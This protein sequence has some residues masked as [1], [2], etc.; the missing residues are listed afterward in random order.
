MREEVL[1]RAHDKDRLAKDLAE[2]AEGTTVMKRPE[3][4]QGKYGA[5]GD[6]R[7]RKGDP[8]IMGAGFVVGDN[9]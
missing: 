3:R 8:C 7:P 1:R 9:P 4:G 5:I 2:L 6:G